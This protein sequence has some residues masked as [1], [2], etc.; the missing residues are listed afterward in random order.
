MSES[1]LF[2]HL[3]YSTLDD[4]NVPK[5]KCSLELIDFE[6]ELLKCLILYY[7]YSCK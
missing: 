5:I 6:L 1:D 3:K 7:K 2:F 4:F